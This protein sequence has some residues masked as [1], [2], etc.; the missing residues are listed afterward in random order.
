[1]PSIVGARLEELTLVEKA[2]SEIFAEPLVT[3]IVMS[4]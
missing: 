3:R 4:A 1:M 2:G